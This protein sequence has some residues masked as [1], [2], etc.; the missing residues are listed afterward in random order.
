VFSECVFQGSPAASHRRFSNTIILVL[1]GMGRFGGSG[2]VG[3]CNRCWGGCPEEG[4]RAQ[5]MLRCIHVGLLCVQE[6]PHL[7]RSMA[8]VVVML[9][10]RS[11]TLPAPSAPAYAW[12]WNHGHERGSPEPDGCRNIWG[13]SPSTTSPFLTWSY[14]KESATW[15]TWISQ[16]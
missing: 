16:L 15:T 10:S 12:P 4:R 8:S 3:A 14:V 1:H 11:I 5:E 13:A 6:D 2:A 9:N 7:R